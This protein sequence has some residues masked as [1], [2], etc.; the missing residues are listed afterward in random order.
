M[1]RS[2][3]RCLDASL[4]PVGRLQTPP[5]L[6]ASQL[7]HATDRQGELVAHARPVMQYLYAQ[8]RDT[9]SMVILADERGTL[10]QTLGDTDFLGRAERVALMQGASWHESQQGTNA[11]G[12]AIAEIAPVVVHG[13]EHFLER[14]GF[15]TCAAAP[16]MAPDGRLLGV[17]DISGD[18]RGHHPHTIGLVRSAAQMIEN[19]LFETCHGDTIRVRFHPLAEGIGTVAEGIIVLKEDGWITCANHAGLSLLGLCPAD[20]GAMPVTRV[21]QIG[22]SELAS[23]GRR[24][25][26]EIM[27]VIRNNGERIFLRV[28]LGRGARQI[29][30]P[31]HPQEEACADSLEPLNTGDAVM[32]A[33]IEKARR[34]VGKPIALLLQG[35]S[36]TGKEIFAKAFHDSGPRRSKPF[37]AVDCATLPENLIEAEL[38][39]YM[40]GA[41]SGARKEGYAGRIRSAIGGTLFLD[42]IGD[43]P[44]AQQARLLRVLQEREVVPV[45]GSKPIPVDFVLVCATHRN[46]KTEMEAERFRADL[47]YRINGLTLMLPP[48][49]ERSDFAA[50]TS[51]VLRDLSP[52]RHLYLGDAVA[53]AFAKYSWPGNLRQLV[54]ALRTACALLNDDESTILWDHL[55]DDLINELRQA[56]QSLDISSMHLPQEEN[57]HVLSSA[58]ISRAIDISDGNMSEAARRLGISRNT[59]YRRLKIIK[60]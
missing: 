45:G 57:L 27:S 36:G 60:S 55:P 48:L 32:K 12:T 1:S 13:P 3:R 47:Y 26:G 17:L 24:R 2:W 14:N 10:L 34:V 54:N 31:S 38:F 23:W 20:L 22:T 37:V 18:H 4:A 59:L 44:M 6:N 49:R 29:I 52:E 39:G 51:R 28:E 58:A 11:I 46:L 25:P 8:T 43:M 21:F 35:E 56:S 40:P 42:E 50:L 16:V 9:G 53:L 15:L 30:V 5:Q 19:R 33:T 41:F 7:A